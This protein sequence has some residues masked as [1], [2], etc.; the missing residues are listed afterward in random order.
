MQLNALERHPLRFSLLLLLLLIVVQAVGVG[1]AQQMGLPPTTFAV[2]TEAFLAVILALFVSLLHWWPEIGFRLPAARSRLLL[3]LPALALPLGNLTFGIAERAWPALLSAALLALLSGFVEEVAFRGLMLRAFRPTGTWRALLVSTALFGLTH[4]FNVL[5][6]Y[7]PLYALIQIA[8][9]LAIG[10]G[11]GAMVLKGRML[12]PLIL[13]HALG[14][15]VAFINGGEIGPQL[16]LVS[17]FYIL[18]FAGYGF[19]L[20]VT[21][22]ER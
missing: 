7:E 5:A 11:F 8:Y 9:A 6:G 4:A 2:Y 20:M 13:A 12:W 10:F 21:G 22:P 15:F 19:Y 14:N 17:L 3:F 16:Y 1:A 18:L